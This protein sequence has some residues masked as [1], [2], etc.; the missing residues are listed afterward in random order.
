[1]QSKIRKIYVSIINILVNYH[2]YDEVGIHMN[3]LHDIA[4]RIDFL[5]R[6]TLFIV[7]GLLSLADETQENEIY[8]AGAELLFYDIKV[9]FAKL[10]KDILEEGKK[11]KI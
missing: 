8:V 4:D 9:E 11:L 7:Q 5:Q 1:M 3:N 10:T 2:K 6:K